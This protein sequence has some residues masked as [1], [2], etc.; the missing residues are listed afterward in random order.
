[1]VLKH[2]THNANLFNKPNLAEKQQI[3]IHFYR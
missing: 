2:K 3:S 1:M